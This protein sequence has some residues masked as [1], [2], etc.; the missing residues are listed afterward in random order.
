[1]TVTRLFRRPSHLAAHNPERRSSAVAGS[2]TDA[3]VRV[4]VGVVVDRGRKLVTF[5]DT[6]VNVPVAS[7]IPGN[8]KKS[9]GNDLVSRT[10]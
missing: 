7:G 3:T 9:P 4:P 6:E 8:T 10:G 1:L 5:P 2:G